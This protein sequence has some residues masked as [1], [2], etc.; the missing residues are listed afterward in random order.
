MDTLGRSREKQE[1]KVL[2]YSG[3]GKGK[4]T[5]AVGLAVRAVG[6]GLKVKIFQFIKSPE[7]TYGEQLA[8]EKIGVEMIQL[9]EGFT[10][11]KTP[12]I[13]REALRKGWIQARD[14]IMSGEYDVVVLDELNNALAIEAF[15]ID[16]VLPLEDVKKVI[17]D[18]PKHVHLVITGRHARSEIKGMADL[19][20]IVDAEKHY[21]EEGVQAI[22]GI[23][24]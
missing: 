14:A 12:D 6:R 2:L 9:G 3:D 15:P 5:A 4:T 10:W 7:R 11:K 13:H 1:G 18:R 20:S 22:Y 16:D 23:E 24:F 8:L 21:Y 19:I 17:H